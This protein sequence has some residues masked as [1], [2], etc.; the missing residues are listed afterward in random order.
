MENMENVLNIKEA[1]RSDL[2]TS[3][4]GGDKLRVETV[5]A[6][7]N[8]LVN[9]EKSNPGKELDVAKVIKLL[10]GRREDSASAFRQ[11]GAEERAL[12][13]EAEL[14]IINEYADTY[15]PKQMSEDEIRGVLKEIVSVNSGNVGKCMGDFSKKY[16]GLADMGMV[17]NILKTLV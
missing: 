8:E 2:T 13:E 14:K 7:S 6:I 10:K 11:G 1:L 15:L 5:R 12:Q 4:K 3:M 16:K 9:F 17:S